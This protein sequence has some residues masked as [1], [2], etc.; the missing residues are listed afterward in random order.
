MS[1]SLFEIYLVKTGVD[2]TP[3]RNWSCDISSNVRIEDCGRGGSFVGV[4][5]GQSKSIS[6]VGMIKEKSNLCWRF[7]LGKAS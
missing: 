3:P 4:I 5:P 2:P 7:W 1:M 6:G